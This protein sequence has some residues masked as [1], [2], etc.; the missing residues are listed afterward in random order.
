M[1]RRRC[2][3]GERAVFQLHTT[4][5]CSHAAQRVTDG[6]IISTHFGQ[7]MRTVTI[8][9]LDVV[10]YISNSKSSQCVSG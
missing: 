8:P 3:C 1:A 6:H 9:D 10:V 4:V 5:M 7:T 2:S